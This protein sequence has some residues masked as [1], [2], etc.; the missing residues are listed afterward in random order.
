MPKLTTAQLIEIDYNL[1]KEEVNSII[2]N[3]ILKNGILIHPQNRWVMI[4]TKAGYN[5]CFNGI[6]IVSF[7]KNKLGLN[8]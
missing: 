3:G 7:I 6:R 5:T 4:P 1:Q 2:K 8:T